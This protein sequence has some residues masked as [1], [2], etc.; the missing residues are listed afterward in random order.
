[1]GKIKYTKNELKT[2]R[3]ALKRFRRYLPTLLLKKQQLQMELRAL[4]IRIEEKN[5]EEKIIFED[6]SPWIKLFAAP[7]DLSRYIHL[8]EVKTSTGNIAGV[9]IPVLKEIVLHQMTPDLH[10]TASWIDDGIKSIER[11][12]RLRIEQ[13]ILREQ[14]RLIS[15][16]L[17]TTSQRVNLFEKVKIPEAKN[18]IRIIRIFLGDVQTSE[19]ARGKIAKKKSAVGGAA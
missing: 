4:D 13:Q 10:Q 7:E 1:M 14:H 12:L 2:Q 17:R 8:L 15:D 19:V 5:A 11:I 3:D 9:N 16:E 6:L 18:N